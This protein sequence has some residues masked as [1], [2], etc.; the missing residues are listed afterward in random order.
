MVF[1]SSVHHSSKGSIVCPEGVEWGVELEL[2][3]HSWLVRS[4]G[5]NLDLEWTSE[6]GAAL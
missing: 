5:D 1:L 3:I 2:T 6:V 4:Q